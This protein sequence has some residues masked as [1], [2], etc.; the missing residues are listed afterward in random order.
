MQLGAVLVRVVHSNGHNVLI[1]YIL[2]A[3]IGGLDRRIKLC[4]SVSFCLVFGGALQSLE[5]VDNIPMVEIVLLAS[6]T[7]VDE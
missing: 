1:I 2:L 4:P 7:M 3:V 5:A 6:L